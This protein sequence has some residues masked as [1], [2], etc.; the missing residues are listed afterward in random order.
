MR[1]EPAALVTRGRVVAVGNRLLTSVGQAE[2]MPDYRRPRHPGATVFFSVALARRGSMVLSC[3]VDHLRDA[4]TR[5]RKE[6][7][8]GIDAFVVLPDHLHAVW[9]LPPG[10]CDFSARWGAIKA[11]FSMSMRRA[12]FTPP[13]GERERSGCGSQGSGNTTS[14]IRPITMRM[15]AIA[16]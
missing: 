15:S 5:T 13:Y 11:R 16:G 9:T 6:R 2:G 8:F 12:G 14:A 1:W 7:P 3:N 10:D 4:V